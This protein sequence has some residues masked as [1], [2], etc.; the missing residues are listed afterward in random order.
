MVAEAK[1]RCAEKICLPISLHGIRE[2]QEVRHGKVVCLLFAVVAL[3]LSVLS[4]RCAGE[5]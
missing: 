3:S 1:V 5:P 4:S 2:K